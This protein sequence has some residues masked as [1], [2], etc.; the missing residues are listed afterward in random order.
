MKSK[1][2]LE[3]KCLIVYLRKYASIRHGSF[4]FVI[5]LSIVCISV[6]QAIHLH[7]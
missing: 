3:T 4:E 2:F 5:T 1:T 6:V 7:G